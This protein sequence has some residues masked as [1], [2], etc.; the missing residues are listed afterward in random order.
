[1]IQLTKMWV[2][3]VGTRLG[4]KG[5]ISVSFSKEMAIETLSN[6]T[7]RRNQ[8]REESKG[9]KNYMRMFWNRAYNSSYARE[10]GGNG[11]VMFTLC[12]LDQPA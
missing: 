8:T 10:W 3:N 7:F 4:L 6:K 9:E 2:W 1:M 5:E 11:N 12:S